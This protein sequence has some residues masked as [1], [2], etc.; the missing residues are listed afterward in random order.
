MQPTRVH[1][2]DPRTTSWVAE[3]LNR[4]VTPAAAG[5][6]EWAGKRDRYGYGVI[7][8][9]VAGKRVETGA[10]R[11]AWIVAN[12]PVPRGLVIDHLCRNRA[13]VNPEHLEAVTGAENTRRSQIVGRTSGSAQRN[14]LECVHGHRFEPGNTLI[15]V[16]K[17]GYERRVCIACR[18]R[19]SQE[20]RA[21]IRLSA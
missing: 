1:E 2:I 17:D 10:H 7:R 18:R 20:H 5:C 21:R 19:R 6:V 9:R 15:A 11:L 14:K 8:V 4:C 16:S 13:C 12:G 3:R